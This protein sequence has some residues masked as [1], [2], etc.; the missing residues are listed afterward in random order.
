MIRYEFDI[1]VF[2]IILAKNLPRN[3]WNSRVWT[4]EE[5][6]ILLQYIERS[7]RNFKQIVINI[8]KKNYKNERT[9]S[10]CKKRIKS[11]NKTPN[12]YKIWTQDETK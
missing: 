4:R 1:I 12:E 6:E 3:S 10:E 5:D 2:L 8:N 9:L 7:E 11:L